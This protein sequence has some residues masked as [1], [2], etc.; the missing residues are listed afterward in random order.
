MSRSAAEK[1]AAREACSADEEWW[2]MSGIV[3]VL[4]LVL[5]DH[6]RCRCGPVVVNAGAVALDGGTVNVIGVVAGEVG[7]R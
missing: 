4:L 1:Y 5:G 2:L 7:A 3:L 6:G